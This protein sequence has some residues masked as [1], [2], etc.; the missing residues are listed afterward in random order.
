MTS[1]DNLRT[2]GETKSKVARLRPAAQL[3]LRAYRPPSELRPEHKDLLKT[4]W[5]VDQ[6]FDGERARCVFCK[7]VK[8]L[9]DMT[10]HHDDGVRSHNDFDNLSP[11]CYPC[12][13][14]ESLKVM[15]RQRAEVRSRERKSERRV[16]TGRPANPGEL[17][18]E[19]VRHDEGLPEVTRA[20][21]RRIQDGWRALTAAKSAIVDDV[22]LEGGPEYK[23][24][25]A[26]LKLR[27]IVG[28]IFQEH[29]VAVQTIY[30]YFMGF[31]NP[32]NGWCVLVDGP[33][34]KLL[35]FVDPLD[36]KRDAEE[37]YER[38]RAGRSRT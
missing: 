24:A 33:D 14:D 7:V 15:R 5:S 6:G 3:I 28:S 23:R 32:I 11:A 21:I 38:V 20:V 13:K 35:D 30:H 8:I 4:V 31:K 12:N 9:R 19:I 22:A 37:V 26:S 34:G 16:T 27:S 29:D 10:V 25:V 2:R 36:H 18:E 1:S 17:S